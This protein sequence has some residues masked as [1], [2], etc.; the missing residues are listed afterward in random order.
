VVNE[1]GWERGFETPEN[2]VVILG[3]DG[4]VVGTATGSKRRVAEA[5]WDAV[6]AVRSGRG[7]PT[8]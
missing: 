6:L 7:L 8:S 3:A 4:A 1:V 5:V 2:A